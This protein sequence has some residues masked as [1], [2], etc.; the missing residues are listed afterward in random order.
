MFQ[1]IFNE[2]IA[3]INS[4]SLYADELNLPL[5][6]TELTV[7]KLMGI[8]TDALVEHFVFKYNNSPNPQV[9]LIPVK[10]KWSNLHPQMEKLNRKSTTNNHPEP[11]P[12]EIANP[13]DLP[14]RYIQF[15]A[16]QFIRH[17]KFGSIYTINPNVSKFVVSTNPLDDEIDE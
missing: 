9:Y 10:N 8:D 15:S 13:S 12:F 1:E 7:D 6:S 14:I 4:N 5:V 11:E 3:V 2:K 17:A 16:K